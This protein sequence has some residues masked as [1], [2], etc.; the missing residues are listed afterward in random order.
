[1]AVIVGEKAW[2]RYVDQLRR[3]DT[4]ATKA[5]T[6]LS[7]QIERDI[8]SG[9]ITEQAGINKIIDIAYGI[10]TKYGEAAATRA[11]TMYDALAALS[12]AKIPAA[13]PAKTATMAEA[14]KVVNA[15]RKFG[16]N[17]TAQA[18]GRMVRQ[19]GADT[20]MQNAVRD[21][22]Y[23][24]WIPEGGETCAFCI[25]LASQGWLPASEEQLAGGHAEHIHPNCNCT[26]AIRFGAELDIGGYEPDKYRKMY[27]EADGNS[28]QEKI[29]AMRRDI[30]EDNKDEI[31]AQKR[32]AYAERTADEI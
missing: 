21:K 28:P 15:T 29:N 14:A 32:I 9:K 2:H 22:A 8:I 4:T 18:V 25:T 19:A 11:A 16:T 7:M 3:I 27:D 20:M 30:Y 24:A 6:H 17:M 26:F 1:M 12:K 23:W 31:N 10:A 13:V 5:F